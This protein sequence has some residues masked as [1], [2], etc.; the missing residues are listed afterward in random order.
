MDAN[1]FRTH[2]EEAHRAVSHALPFRPSLAIVLG[3]GLGGV[4]EAMEMAGELPYHAIPHHPV[5]TVASHEGRYLWGRWAGRDILA[6]QG[7][8]HLYEGYSPLEISFPVRL[9]A[10]LGVQTLVISNAAGGLNPLF[11]PGDLMLITDHINF[12]G[13]NPLVGP[14]FDEIGPRFPDMTEPYSRRLQALARREALAQGVLLREGVYVG[15][16]GPSM[17]TAAETRM[18]RALGADAVGM[19]TVMEVIAAVHAGLDVLGISVISNVNRP[20]CYE[21]V[22]LEKVIATASAAGPKLMRLLE[23]I[24]PGL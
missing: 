19:S 23:R 13:R 6:L 9:L 24:L 4:A 1:T 11:E 8:F 5:S 17:E 20:D 10:R 12:T 2:L 18:L 3:T 21:P 16:L 14:N 22:P 15:V 7:R